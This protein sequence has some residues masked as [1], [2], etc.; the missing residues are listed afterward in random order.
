MAASLLGRELFVA[1]ATGPPPIFPAATS[2]LLW[3]AAMAHDEGPEHRRVFGWVCLLGACS[4]SIPA[5]GRMGWPAPPVE[6][7]LVPCF[8]VLGYYAWPDLIARGARAFRWP[9]AA[10][11]F[12][13][14]LAYFWPDAAGATARALGSPI[15]FGVPCG[16]AILSLWI[17]PRLEKLNARPIR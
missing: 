7:G 17:I 14:G 1:S 12:T 11:L 9:V 8:F 16:V 4:F 13:A 2:L 15:V 6:V 10:L 5:L 3:V